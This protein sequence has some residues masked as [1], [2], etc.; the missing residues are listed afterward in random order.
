VPDK[1]LEIEDGDLD[2]IAIEMPETNE[3]RSTCLSNCRN[4]KQIIPEISFTDKEKKLIEWSHI[5]WY[6]KHHQNLSYVLMEIWN[7]WLVTRSDPPQK[8]D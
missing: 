6:D 3:K 2:I 5:Q 8:T 7:V 1:W 4:C